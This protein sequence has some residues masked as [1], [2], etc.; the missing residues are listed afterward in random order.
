MSTQWI[1]IS[2][3]GDKE[4]SGYLA[5]PPKGTGPGLILLQEI[6]GVN[7]HIKA[8]AEQYAM[9]GFVVMAPDVFWPAMSSA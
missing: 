5:L 8:V 7:D 6:W 1:N 3:E 2:N 4:F 9:S